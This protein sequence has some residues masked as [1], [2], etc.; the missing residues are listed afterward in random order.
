MMVNLAQPVRVGGELPPTFTLATITSKVVVYTPAER[1][2]TLPLYPEYVLC[3]SIFQHRA[4]L[5]APSASF[6]PFPCAGSSYPGTV[7]KYYFYSLI[8]NSL[9]VT[10]K[11]N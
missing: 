7:K 6:S 11:H 8:K 3:G 2:D 10:I 5:A 4:T 1:A 9:Q